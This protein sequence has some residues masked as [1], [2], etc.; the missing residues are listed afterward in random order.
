MLN[1]P[2]HNESE[3]SSVPPGH[4]SLPSGRERRRPNKAW[5]L[6]NRQCT[7]SGGSQFRV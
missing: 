3:V 7:V 5:P 4:P 6:P 1:L 2:T